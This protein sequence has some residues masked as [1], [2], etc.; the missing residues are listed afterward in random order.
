MID[1]DQKQRLA[2]LEAKINAAKKAQ[3]TE[4]P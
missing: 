2:Q 1:D 3:E 4:P